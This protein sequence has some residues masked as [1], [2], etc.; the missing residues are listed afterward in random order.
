MTYIGTAL[1]QAVEERA[2]GCCEYCRMGQQ[3]RAIDFVIDHIIAEKH[4]GATYA[5]NLCLAA[6][7]A[8]ATKAA[9][10]VPW[11]GK[12]TLKLCHY[13]TLVIRVGL[14]IFT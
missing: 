9:T 13:T 1:R 12:P 14:T 8:T 6:T 7:G 10:S 3:E 2:G 4:G 11:I 5:D